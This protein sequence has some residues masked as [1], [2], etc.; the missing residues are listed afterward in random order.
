M[1]RGTEP[2]RRPEPLPGDYLAWSSEDSG[3]LRTAFKERE[4]F[5]FSP[6]I[7]SKALLCQAL[8]TCG[9]VS[10]ELPERQR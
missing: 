4:G 8:G 6:T 7:F 1:E 2:E 9:P 10:M 5:G 3:D